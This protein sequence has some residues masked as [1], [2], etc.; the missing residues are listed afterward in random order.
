MGFADDT[1]RLAGKKE[2]LASLVNCLDTA[3]TAYGMQISAVKTKL[4]TNNAN[5]I[6]TDIVQLF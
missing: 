3:S 4:M 5:G 2:E 1:D 6:S